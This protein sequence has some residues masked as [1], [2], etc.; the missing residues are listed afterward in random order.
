MVDHGE[1]KPWKVKPWLRVTTVLQLR[2][3]WPLGETRQ[4]VHSIS[5]CNFLQL[6]LNLQLSQNKKFNLKTKTEMIQYTI[7]KA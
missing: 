5:T 3:M 7:I 2:K 1:L 6:H 4:S